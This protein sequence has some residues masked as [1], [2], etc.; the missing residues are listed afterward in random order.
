LNKAPDIDKKFMFSKVGTRFNLL[1]IE[2]KITKTCLLLLSPHYSKPWDIIAKL[3]SH[4]CNV[5]GGIVDGIGSNDRFHYSINFLQNARPFYIPK[6]VNFQ[7]KSVG[8]WFQSGKTNSDLDMHSMSQPAQPNYEMESLQQYNTFLSVSDDKPHDFLRYMG[9]KYPNA[10]NLGLIGS[11]TTFSNGMPF[12]LFYG[13][14]IISSGLV[15]VAMNCNSKLNTAHSLVPI[16]KIRKITSCRGNIILS[17]EEDRASKSLISLV[18]GLQSQDL[19][20]RI[21]MPGLETSFGTFKIIGG[22]FAKGTLALNTT[23]D[24]APGMECQVKGSNIVYDFGQK[25]I[26]EPT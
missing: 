18:Q 6:G 24:L 21:S 7:T 19:Y 11:K 23:I 20:S 10:L 22:D 3:S 4:G 14:N 2:S 1:G 26:A 17:L 5:V 15:G 25:T 13:G 16:G 8:R 12:T 9:L